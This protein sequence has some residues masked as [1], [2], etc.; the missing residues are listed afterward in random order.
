M[1]AEPQPAGDAWARVRREIDD[2]AGQSSEQVRRSLRQRAFWLLRYHLHQS[3]NPAYREL[4]Q[5]AGLD[6]ASLDPA[7]LDPDSFDWQQ[8]PVIDKQWL[9]AA[10]YHRQPAC[11]GPTLVVSTSGSTAAQV[12]VPVT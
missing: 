10:G 3:R 11:A 4:L 6:P 12:L 2:V 8:V 5:Q 7:S 9:A 1:P